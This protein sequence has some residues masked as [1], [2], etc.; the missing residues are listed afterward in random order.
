MEGMIFDIKKFAVHDGPGIRTTLFFK[1]CPLSCRWCHNP[2]SI[3]PDPQIVF[4]EQ[5]CIGCKKCFE[6]CET[7]ALILTEYGRKYNPRKCVL[8]GKCV[9]TCYAEAQVMEGRTIT[10]EEAV[11]EIEKDRPFYENSGGGATFSGG[12]PMMQLD[13]LI[14]LAKECKSRDFH[15]AL[16]TSGYARW[17]NYLKVIDS[18][19]LILYDMKHMDPAK[20]KKFTGVEN[21]L[22]LANARRLD[23]HGKTMWIRVPVVPDCND[24]V[25]NMQAAADYFRDF[26]HVERVELLPYHRLAESKYRRLHKHYSLEGTETPP[27]KRLKELAKPFED[28]GLN[29]KIG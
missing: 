14:A 2:E 12:E 9:E 1:G 3:S 22:I 15:T 8:C 6:A 17:E 27:E 28:A 4:F 19:D 29:V 13:F 24:S 20:H 5:K 7:G 10:V 23:K 26:R 21:K 16:D 25:E 11:K 18:I